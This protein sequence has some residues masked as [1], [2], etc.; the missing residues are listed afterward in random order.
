MSRYC[1]HQYSVK[2][3]GKS[4]SKIIFEF[5]ENDNLGFGKE[6]IDYIKKLIKEY[7]K[8]YPNVT[9]KKCAI[10]FHGIISQET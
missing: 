7:I 5:I 9:L 1:D 4:M 3:E 8:R 2:C 10:S 6:Q